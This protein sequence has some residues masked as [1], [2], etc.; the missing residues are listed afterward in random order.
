MKMKNDNGGN[1]ANSNNN[2][3]LR[4]VTKEPVNF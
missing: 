3:L 2:Y 4:L 1:I